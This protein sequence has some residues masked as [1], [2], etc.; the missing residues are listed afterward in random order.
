MFT[1][2]CCL[3]WCLGRAPLVLPSPALAIGDEVV[4]AG[5]LHERSTRDD[6]PYQRRSTIEV[7]VFVLR[8]E[9]EHIDAAVMT[10]VRP[11]EDAAITNA[12]VVVTGTDPTKTKLPSA[13]SLMLVRMTTRGDVVQLLPNLRP[14]IALTTTTPSQPLAPPKLDGPLELEL[15]MFVPL[16]A[17]APT[18]G[19]TWTSRETG[20]P[21]LTWSV[22]Q[23]GVR[24]GAQLLEVVGEH[25]SE[26]WAKPRGATT[27]WR[28]IDTL[29]LSPA[30]GLARHFT[31]RIEH[32]DGVPIVERR[33]LTMTMTSPPTPHRGDSYLAVRK[34]IEFA[35][36]FQQ[37]LSTRSP[38]LLDKIESHLSRFRETP[39]RAAIDAVARSAN[40]NANALARP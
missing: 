30:D 5:E 11:L 26:H 27:S 16:P 23:L 12:A 4:Y 8:A 19:D 35:L 15:G 2:T 36:S 38:R 21:D 25:A 32:R 33:T 18:V 7:R 1:F 28:R 34:E 9:R 40:A 6:R 20:R 3:A 29:W 14:P 37:E 31:R 24:D 17:N 39:Y 22:L 13:V 10:M